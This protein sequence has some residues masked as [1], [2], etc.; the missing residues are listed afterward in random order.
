MR[1]YWLLI[2]LVACGAEET[3]GAPAPCPE[4][5]KLGAEQPVFVEA[6]ASWG[7]TDLAPAGVRISAV[8]F[9]GDGWTDL[10]VRSSGADTWGETRKNWLLRN[11]GGGRFEDVT[12]ASGI[13]LRRGGGGGGRPGPV[14]VFGD[15]DNDGDLDVY[16]GLPD[17]GS[18]G[19]T[20]ELMLNNGDGTFSL[21]PE[22]SDLRRAAGDMP[23]GASF[24][25]VDKDGRVDLWVA[26]YDNSSGPQRDRLYRNLG[27]G[28][29]YE[30][31]NDHGIDSERWSAL[32]DLNEGR[33]HTR[34][35]AALACDLNDDG[36]P[37]L[38]SASY[39]RSPN[40]LWRANGD[41]TYTNASVE[42]G[43]AFDDR[44]DWS[45]NESA[46]CWCTLH[47]EAPGCGDVPEPEAIRCNSDD[48][49]FRW[50]HDYD[51][52]PFRLG[53]NSGATIC[54]D[55]DNDGR[56][57]L[58]TSE[59]VHWDVGAS[60]DP[61]E[62]LFNTGEA[63]VRFE[64]PGN[65]ATGLTRVHTISDWNDGDITGSAFD[66][67]NDGRMDL[68][69]G[70][71][72]YPGARGLLYHNEGDRTFTPVPIELGIDH[73]RSHGSAIADFDRDGDLDI[74][75]GH[76]TARCDDDCYDTAVVR[77]FENQSGN[78]AHYLE[79]EL[80]GTGGANRAAIGAQIRLTAD[81]LLQTHQVDG[82]H[83]Q[84]GQQDDLRQYFG[85]GDTCEAE[86]EIRWPD[87]AGTV[88]R[89]TLQGPGRVKIRQG[90]QPQAVD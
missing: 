2:G 19:E 76:S 86:V 33:A 4:F 90:G 3:K 34:A 74:V 42:S 41:G 24:V 62:L 78:G 20:S 18:E 63:S 25:D 38:L 29:F 15:V 11:T 67:D 57:D 49:A 83:G 79:L 27:G 55:A 68:Y 60:S 56:M 54:V 59:I 1:P 44:T 23:Y 39:G 73:M 30:V 61:S 77:F 35:W 28:R 5:S 14:W 84:W 10:A 46:C 85:L 26:Q 32:S 17:D 82:G 9:D 81:G 88:E 65:E 8:D 72:D 22:D 21:G 6:T 66:F 69:I 16:T 71:S 58:L 37:E 64:R 45:D 75:V 13:L 48:D 53:G 40:H 87:A 51:R 70:S 47:P 50:D 52:E 89:F 31:A 43:Y 80:E 12:E 7:L 36:W